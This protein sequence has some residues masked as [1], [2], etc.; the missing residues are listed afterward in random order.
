[1]TKM[2]KSE[3]LKGK[4][5]NIYTDF[6]RRFMC[7]LNGNGLSKKTN[8]L[9]NNVPKENQKQQSFVKKKDVQAK[10]NRLRLWK[11]NKFPQKKMYFSFFF[12]LFF[13][14]SWFFSNF[15]D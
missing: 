10:K 11:I 3:S 5:V 14:R 4:K 8:N 15:F 12:G 2:T 13:I 1:M 7:K 6:R 9:T